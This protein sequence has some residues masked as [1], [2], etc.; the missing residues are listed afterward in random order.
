[1]PLKRV[2]TTLKAKIYF[3]I[4]F[5]AAIFLW[6]KKDCRAGFEQLVLNSRARSLGNAVTAYPPGIMS[7]HYNPAGLT[8]F[9]GKNISFDI[10][11]IPNFKI[12]S[13]FKKD[14]WFFGFLFQLG[15]VGPIF[16]E[17]FDI[18][19][20]APDSV[21]GTQTS[22]HPFMKLP[23][24]NMLNNA[25]F[26]M[27]FSG[28]VSY[29]DPESR[30]AMA[31][32]MYPAMGFGFEFDSDSPARFGAKSSNIMRYLFCAPAVSYKIF[33][34][35]SLGF[36]AGMGKAAENLDMTL[37][38]PNEILV[39]STT[40]SDLSEFIVTNIPELGDVFPAP[41][42]GG[43]LELYEPVGTFKM[44]IFDNMT[45]SFNIGLLWDPFTWFSAGLVYQSE[46]KAK[47]GG[48]YRISY[49]ES[50]YNL[51]NWFQSNEI[52][53]IVAQEMG[54]PE[55]SVHSQIGRVS[56]KFKFPMRFQC[57]IMLRPFKT[58]RLMCDYHWTNWSVWKEDT[59]NFDQ[60]IHLLQVMQFL[61]H[62]QGPRKITLKRDNKD[63]R[64]FSY[65]LEWQ[66]VKGVFLRLGYEPKNS[67]IQKNNFSL[68]MPLT[69]MTIYSAG[70]GLDLGSFTFDVGYSYLKSDKFSL[71]DLTG[72]YFNLWGAPIS[73]YVGINYE[74]EIT[75]EF[76]TFAISYKW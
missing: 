53:M 54:L 40:L 61:G 59:F 16:Y 48:D 50:F 68:T 35:L 12:D 73:P 43:G 1:M 51:T 71:P 14:P 29:H 18:D 32:G 15:P 11:Y 39:L 7:V 62:T 57:G 58:L 2:G 38:F 45:T 67:M 13:K 4:F 33:N 28:G 8:G 23:F 25:S 19:P 27:T 20:L 70:L 44:D 37:R 17:L 63:T 46:S 34:T 9:N 10:S 56:T 60:D 64:H 49:S 24:G 30:W 22:S 6:F 74:Q 55:S 41:W 42:L 66:A 21:A 76:Y 52:L 65:G 31:Y 36:S 26:G 3:T 5:M 47:M 75:A 72:R 69:K